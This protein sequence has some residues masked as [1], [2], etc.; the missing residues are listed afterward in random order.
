MIE[1]L[2]ITFSIVFPFMVFLFLG[3]FLKRIGILN[4]SF[5]SSVN[6]LNANVLFAVNVF[7]NLY[8]KGFEGIFSFL[9]LYV[10][11]GTVAVLLFLLNLRHFRSLH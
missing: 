3:M 5:V 8:K 6:K 10:A 11:L 2:R 4:D 1:N 9:S 7:N